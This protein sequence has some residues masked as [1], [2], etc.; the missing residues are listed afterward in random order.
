MKQYARKSVKLVIDGKVRVREVQLAANG[1]VVTGIVGKARIKWDTAK[2][3]MPSVYFNGKQPK[4]DELKTAK[5]AIKL[6]LVEYKKMIAAEKIQKEA[7]V[8]AIPQNTSKKQYVP[9]KFNVATAT[10]KREVDGEVY[11][12]IL[13]IYKNGDEFSIT[14]MQSGLKICSAADNTEARKFVKAMEKTGIDWT[15]EPG[16]IDKK[17]LD[18]AL[19]AMGAIVKSTVV[20]SPVA[21]GAVTNEAEVYN[22]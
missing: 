2:Y 9:C 21:G 16:T 18:T 17:V 19:V 5:Q 22:D 12:N 4:G 10:G 14:H 8:T 15:K 7:A 1:P 11:K 20:E 3:D 6:Y 13:G